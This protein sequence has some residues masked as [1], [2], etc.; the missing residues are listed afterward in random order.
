MY[1]FSDPNGF[2][3]KN[4]LAKVSRFN[5]LFSGTELEPESG[6]AR[7]VFPG[8]ETGTAGTFFSEPK[9]E[10][11]LPLSLF[12]YGTEPF[13]TQTGTQPNRTRATLQI[14]NTKTYET[15]F[16]TSKTLL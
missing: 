16:G 2:R 11:E 8:T 10:P 9:P 14:T 15:I 6:T 12:N 13:R 4:N 7:S 3:E 1:G 5:V